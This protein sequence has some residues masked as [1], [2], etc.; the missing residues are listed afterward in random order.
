MS[1]N[2]PD[3]R[4]TFKWIS[5]T[6]LNSSL[7]VK[8][9]SYWFVTEHSYPKPIAQLHQSLVHLRPENYKNATYHVLFYTQILTTL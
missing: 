8:V 2:E 4:R 5:G 6:M 1:R 7:L 3:V 9:F